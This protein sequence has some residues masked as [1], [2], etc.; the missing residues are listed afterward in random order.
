MRGLAE[1]SAAQAAEPVAK[2]EVFSRLDAHYVDPLEGRMG[3]KETCVVNAAIMAASYGG[4]K[5]FNKPI[6]V[7]IDL[8]V[9][10]G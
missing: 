8:P 6:V 3:R 10:R 1:R 2:D 4:P 7:D 9:W 5:R